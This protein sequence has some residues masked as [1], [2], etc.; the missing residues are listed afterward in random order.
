[1]AAQ[2]HEV[3]KPGGYVYGEANFVFAY[4]TFGRAT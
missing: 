1:V 2:I 3:L 4:H